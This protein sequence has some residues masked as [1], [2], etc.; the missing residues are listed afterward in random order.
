MEAKQRRFSIGYA[1]ATL[2]AIFL[3]QA[4]LFAPHAE[5]L[6]YRSLN[7]ARPSARYR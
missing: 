5:N 3:V 7:P 1:I 6:T 2:I 4:V